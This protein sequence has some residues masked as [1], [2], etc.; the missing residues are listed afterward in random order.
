MAR[1]KGVLRHKLSKKTGLW[2]GAIKEGKK[3][4]SRGIA[5]FLLKE[6]WRGLECEFE[7]DEELNIIAIWVNGDPV[8]KDNTLLE[9]REQKEAAKKARL[10]AEEETKRN[11]EALEKAQAG[12]VYHPIM[13]KYLP[14]DVKQLM[15]AL[16]DGPDN[17]SLKLNQTANWE[18]DKAILFKADRT[19]N[20]SLQ[21]KPAPNYGLPE[22]I[23]SD[24]SN[25]LAQHADVI[26]ADSMSFELTQDAGS[27]LTIGLGTATVYETGI[28]LHPVYGFPY[29]PATSVKGITRSW[30]IDC[31]FEG[32][33][34]LAISKQS[35]C[36]LFGCPDHVEV[37]EEGSKKK[38]KHPSYYYS[39]DQALPKSEKKGGSRVGS[40]I[41]FDAFPTQ[42]PTIK[43]DIMNPHYGDYY[44]GKELTPPADYLTPN[45]IN[46]L[47][48]ENTTFQFHIGAKSLP[49]SEQVV[50]G[51]IVS[52]LSTD[53][54]ELSPIE[55]GKQWLIKA[56]S[57]HGIGAKTALGYGFFSPPQQS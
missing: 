43:E 27:R 24:L 25:N 42:A 55:A 26:A 28:L 54:T 37:Q 16:P 5:N 14:E 47:T 23:W 4:R 10:A 15:K 2:V 32:K 17:Y 44:S 13:A 11:K 45:I 8:P 9:E 30:I 35:F 36:D 29:L 12:G 7:L 6:E 21:Y 39:I 31:C 34:E 40:L 46:F 51:D 33:E 22:D 20:N 49:G 3:D 57:E 19:S 48:V 18:G 52:N 56:L 38:I 41:F 53:K 1:R 50:T